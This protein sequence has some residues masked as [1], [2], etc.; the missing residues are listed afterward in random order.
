M[1]YVESEAPVQSIK[2][3][4]SRN[5]VRCRLRESLLETTQAQGDSRATMAQKHGP[6]LGVGR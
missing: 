5:A 6:A 4:L 2:K 3:K 1:L